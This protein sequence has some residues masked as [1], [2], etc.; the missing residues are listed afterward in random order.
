MAEQS[1]SEDYATVVAENIGPAVQV[2]EF[3]D[4]NVG[5]FQEDLDN[6]LDWGLVDAP[7][8]AEDLVDDTFADAIVAA[9]D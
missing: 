4:E 8:A 7:V 3:T 6:L 9:R 2:L 1:T 5:R